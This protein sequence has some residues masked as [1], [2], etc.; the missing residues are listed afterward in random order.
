MGRNMHGLSV[1]KPRLTV[2][3]IGS[4]RKAKTLH[5]PRGVS[6]GSTRVGNAGPG[7]RVQRVVAFRLLTWAFSVS[8]TATIP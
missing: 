2:R 1:H 5:G 4:E 3:L 7:T 6:A 8:S